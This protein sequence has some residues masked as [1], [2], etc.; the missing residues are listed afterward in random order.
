MTVHKGLGIK[1][2]S[3]NKGK[4]NR[5]PGSSAEDYSLLISVAN[6]T[7]LRDE[8]KHVEF[9]LLDEVSLVGLQLL[10]EIDHAPRFAKEKPHLWF[11]GV[12]IIF[13]GDFYQYPPVGGSALYIPISSYAGQNDAEIQ[14]RL[15]RLAWKSLNAVI[16]LNEQ[17]RMKTDPEYGDAVNRLRERRCTPADL[18][19][20]NS[21]IVKSGAHP[22]GVDMGIEGNAEA[23]AIVTTNALRCLNNRGSYIKACKNVM[24]PQLHLDKTSCQS[25]IITVYDF[26]SFRGR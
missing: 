6:R 2:K 11:G 4:G 7:Q 20:F 26:S 5:E 3:K 13:S 18:D 15:G 16:N 10:A 9:L 22:E 12:N 17:Q 25:S 24:T 21:R 19:L 23:A 14:K 8:W 1:I